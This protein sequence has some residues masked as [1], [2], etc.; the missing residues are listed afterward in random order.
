M[1][2]CYMGNILYNTGIALSNVESMST[3]AESLEINLTWVS[4]TFR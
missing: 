3:F 1:E 2:I 4:V